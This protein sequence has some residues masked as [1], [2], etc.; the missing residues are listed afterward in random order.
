MNLLYF[1]NLQL[2][3]K[4]ILAN[5]SL[6]LNKKVM[7]LYP[8]ILPQIETVTEFGSGGWKSGIPGLLT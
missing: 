2:D 7:G 6:F 1:L 5:E 4:F 3:K 8:S